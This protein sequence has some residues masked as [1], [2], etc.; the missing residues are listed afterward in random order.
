M[1]YSDMD[2]GPDA[3]AKVIAYARAIVAS[4]KNIS[5]PS[6]AAA[7]HVRRIVENCLQSWRGRWRIQ[8]LNSMPRRSNSTRPAAQKSI[9]AR[10]LNAAQKRCGDALNKLRAAKLAHTAATAPPVNR[11]ARVLTTG[12]PVPKD[13]S[14]T[15]INPATGQQKAY[16]V[17]DR[18]GARERLRAASPRQLQASQV[19]QRDRDAR[20]GYLCNLCPRSVFLQ[21]HVLHAMRKALSD[22]RGWR[23]RVDRKR[24]LNRAK[25]GN[26]MGERTV[27]PTVDHKAFRRCGSRCSKSTPGISTAMD[28]LALSAHLCGQVIEQDRL[29]RR[30][31]GGPGHARLF[32][33]HA[34][35][36][37]M[38][39]KAEP[40][41][42][43]SIVGGGAMLMDEKGRACGQIAFIGGGVRISKELDAALSARIA[44]LINEQALRSLTRSGLRPQPIARSRDRARPPETS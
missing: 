38:K 27:K 8:K 19:R 40:I 12:K 32:A 31:D 3:D 10:E 7:Q 41:A 25:G 11:S 1:A 26:I 33:A 16:I 20:P 30:A 17:L 37:T 15:E 4:G 42:Y 6:R 39:L 13:W 28:M 14:H 43:S 36:R 22:G 29:R 2:A 18:R 21:R 9:A 23:I 35:G 44:E 24:W 5:Y 34:E